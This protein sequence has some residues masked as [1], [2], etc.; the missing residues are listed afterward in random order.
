MQTETS[1]ASPAQRTL[2]RTGSRAK[3]ER[4]RQNILEAT[5]VVI[6]KRGLHGATHRAIAAEAGVPLSLTTYFF[7]S[8]NDLLEQAFDFL[9]CKGSM[10]HELLLNHLENLLAVFPLD[11]ENPDSREAL[12]RNLTD[13]LTDF[14]EYIVSKQSVCVIVELNFLN[15]YFIDASLRGKAQHHR[16]RMVQRL[17]SLLHPV[18]ANPRQVSTDA[19]LLLGTLHRLELE[20]LSSGDIPPSRDT[21][22]A[23]IE[24]QLGLILGSTIPA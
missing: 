18:A 24:R 4:S 23:Q 2:R 16:D 6:A 12:C 3:G 11:A 10:E 20:C 13:L 5:L 17:A 8:L 1:S 22:A 14:V 19:A 15:L 21:L 9:V 7:S